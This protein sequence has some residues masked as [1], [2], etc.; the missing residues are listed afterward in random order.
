MPVVPCI[1]KTKNPAPPP[2]QVALGV[3]LWSLPETFTLHAPKAVPLPTPE[4]PNADFDTKDVKN[5]YMF[6][7]ISAGLWGGLIIG[8][9]T[10]YFTSNRY[11]PVQ[12]GGKGFGFWDFGS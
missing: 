7:C 10:E 11:K 9:Q 3:A 1:P 2:P 5:W 6:V 8:L 12:V 4:Q